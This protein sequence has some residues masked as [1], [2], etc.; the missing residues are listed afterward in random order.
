MHRASLMRRKEEHTMKPE[1]KKEVS[2]IQAGQERI[3]MIYAINVP[4]VRQW[5]AEHAPKF[6]TYFPFQSESERA[7][8]SPD[9]AVLHVSPLYDFEEVKIY[10][11]SQG[12]TD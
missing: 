12:Q 5:F 9:C 1:P 11:E 8:G 3:L 4:D 6:G 7:F 2:V 10:L